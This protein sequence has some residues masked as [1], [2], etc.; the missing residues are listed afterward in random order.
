MAKTTFA[1]H[2]LHPQLIVVPAGLLPFSFILDLLHQ[3]TGKRSYADAAYYALMGGSVGA[4]AAASAGAADYFTIPPHTPAKQSANVHASMNL[5]L[6][7]MSMANLLLRRGKEPPTGTLPVLLS[8]MSTVGLLI[9]AWY[10]G[11]MVYE[12]GMRVKGVDPSAGAPEIR[13]PLDETGA[14]A[15]AQGEHAA[16]SGEVPRPAR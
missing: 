4:V 7:A 15:L 5:G 10:G 13:P 9:S 2:P 6:L 11:H 1:G 14:A 12:H 16:P 8:A 3:V